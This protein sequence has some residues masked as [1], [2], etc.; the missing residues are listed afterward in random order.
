MSVCGVWHQLVPVKLALANLPP[1][2]VAMVRRVS[3]VS[4]RLPMFWLKGHGRDIAKVL[5]WHVVEWLWAEGHTNVWLAA[6]PDPSAQAADVYDGRDGWPTGAAQGD[7]I[8]QWLE[9]EGVP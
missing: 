7:S 2:E 3:A 8:V 9:A 1:S 5:T 6:N 4:W